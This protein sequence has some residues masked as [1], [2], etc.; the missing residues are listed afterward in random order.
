MTVTVTVTVTEAE[1]VTVTE[2]HH[3]APFLSLSFSF[4]FFSSLFFVAFYNL[5]VVFL[6]GLDLHSMAQNKD[7]TAVSG[8]GQ[9]AS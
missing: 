5:S 7:L 9:F 8:T 3:L 2:T 1:T 4:L 6:E